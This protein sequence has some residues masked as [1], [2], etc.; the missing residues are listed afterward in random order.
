MARRRKR[1][2]TEILGSI[3]SGAAKTVV[4][5]MQA[6]QQWR[7]QA[8]Y[9][10]ARA[11]LQQMQA[12]LLRRQIGGMDRYDVLIDN[13][14]NPPDPS[15]PNV[16]A[17][18]EMPVTPTVSPQAPPVTQ[19]SQGRPGPGGIPQPMLT[20]PQT[21]REFLQPGTTV[22]EVG[23]RQPLPWGAM[24]APSEVSTA[25]Q[26]TSPGMQADLQHFFSGVTSDQGPPPQWLHPITG[27]PDENAA[28]ERMALMVAG[29]QLPP[30]YAMQQWDNLVENPNYTRYWKNQDRAAEEAFKYLTSPE[31]ETLKFTS[32]T[33]QQLEL[34]IPKAGLI[35][36]GVGMQEILAMAE[37]T[38][39]QIAAL[40]RGEGPG[41][42]MGGSPFEPPLPSQEGVP[43]EYVA[44][45]QAM[46]PWS[47]DPST[48]LE[49]VQGV[50]SVRFGPNNSIQGFLTRQMSDGDAEML[51][52]T[53]GVYKILARLQRMSL[54]LNTAKPSQAFLRGAGLTMEA[55]LQTDPQAVAYK[56]AVQAYAAQFAKLGGEGTSRLSDQDIKRALEMVPTLFD[57]AEVA[58]DKLW[59][60]DE[61]LRHQIDG[62]TWGGIPPSFEQIMEQ[63][64]F[65]ISELFPN[66]RSSAPSGPVSSGVG[67]TGSSY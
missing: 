15:S 62:L 55:W 25:T 35:N 56:A 6:Q 44:L 42:A 67:T 29:Q 33:G 54:A 37:R 19:L 51:R 47:E 65:P 49:G 50:H 17:P 27:K 13:F 2:K 1:T 43:D 5:A 20:S 14:L 66:D 53:T 28:R 23:G 31:M 4:P 40:M 38:S 18:Q 57:S 39:P 41:P 11:N 59:N 12:D 60:A 26:S 16:S 8:P 21:G 30:G 3:L 52:E 7:M 58:K 64:N 45:R 9:Y 22:S 24:P 34:R 63:N 48:G 61:F 46:K 10:T 36:A 32:S